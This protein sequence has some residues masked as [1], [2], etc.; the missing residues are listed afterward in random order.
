MDYNKEF[1]LENIKYFCEFDLVWKTEEWNDVV[2]Y[3]GIYKVSDLG[4]VKS[5]ARIVLKK[6][7]YPFLCKERILRPTIG[8]NG[9]FRVVLTLNLTKKIK[10]IHKLVAMAFL[11]HT[12][13]GY[14]LVINHKNF[15]RTD[16]RKLNLEII[17]VRENTNQKHLNSSSEY[18]GVRW[19][20][21]ANKWRSDIRINGLKKYPRYFFNEI[22]AHNAYQ[23]ALSEIKK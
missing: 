8:E 9:Y 23:K 17:T 11:N 10:R 21:N 20:S 19:C 14:E 16:N 5:L 2:D 22:D 12:P 18:V 1:G 15:I 3:E 6:G 7:K 13:C 4:R